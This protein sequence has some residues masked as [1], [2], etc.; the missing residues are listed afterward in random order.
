MFLS[1]KTIAW[2]LKETLLRS[3]WDVG[4]QSCPVYLPG[5]ALSYFTDCHRLAQSRS[6]GGNIRSPQPPLLVARSSSGA[7]SGVSGGAEEVCQWQWN[8]LRDGTS[9]VQNLQKQMLW[10]NAAATLP[11]L[12]AFFCFRFRLAEDDGWFQGS[13]ARQLWQLLCLLSNLNTHKLALKQTYT[14]PPTQQTNKQTQNRT[15]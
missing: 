6:L 1:I 11:S 12:R 2:P 5:S 13:L 15:N 9:H 10:L 8:T 14:P 3:G 7:G 4:S